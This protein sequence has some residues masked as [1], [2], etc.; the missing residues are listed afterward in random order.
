MLRIKELK[1]ALTH[2]D[3]D[4]RDAVLDRLGINPEQLNGFTVFKRSYDARKRSAIVLIYAI[5]ADLVN[6]AEVLARLQHDT[7]ILPS[8]D[9]SYKFVAGGEQLQGHDRNERPIVIG[10]GPCGLFV[11]LVLAQMGLRPLILERG[12]VVRERTVD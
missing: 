11:A 1:L 4:L 10:T 6:E 5:D 8:P 2:S 12:K 3:D 7:H 9:T